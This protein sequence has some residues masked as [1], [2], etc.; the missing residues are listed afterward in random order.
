MRFIATK[1]CLND[2]KPGEPYI[3]PEDLKEWEARIYHGL[4]FGFRML[5]RE[6][7]DDEFLD[8]GSDEV[9]RIDR[10]PDE[11]VSA[12]KLKWKPRDEKFRCVETECGRYIVNEA[13]TDQSGKFWARDYHSVDDSDYFDSIDLAKAWCEE[14]AKTT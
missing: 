6:L 10:V 9:F 12:G 11:A 2:L 3:I 8:C 5:M 4:W 7:M 13:G 14:R 1:V